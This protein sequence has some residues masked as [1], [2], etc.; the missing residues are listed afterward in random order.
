M[1]SRPSALLAGATCLAWLTLTTGYAGA[2]TPS[3]IDLGGEP[4]PGGVGSTTPDRPTALD[5]GLWADTIGGSAARNTH[6]F[7]YDRRMRD[8]TVHVGVIAAP[9]AD[10]TDSIAV[11]V[12]VLDDDG[13]LKSCESDSDTTGFS[14]PQAVIGAA[15]AVGPSS[16][17]ATDR[18]DCLRAATLQVEVG[19][20]SGSSSTSE[21]PVAIKIVEEAPVEDRASLPEPDEDVSFPVPE[22]GGAREVAGGTSFADAPALDPSADGV[23]VSSTVR[24]GTEQLWRVGVGWGQQLAVRATAPK[25]PSED[26]RYSDPNVRLRLVDPRRAV[27]ADTN[28][29]NDDESS[30]GTYDD[31]KTLDLVAGTRPLRYLD[32][33]ADDLPVVPGDYWVALS[34]APADEDEK[35]LDVP[36]EVTVAVTGETD[37]APGYPGVATSP[38]DGDQVASYSPGKPFLVADGT[39]AAVASGNPVVGDDEGDGWLTGRR[40]AGLGVAAVSVACLAG[41]LVRLRARR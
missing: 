15:V 3:A 2:A 1:R 31:G 35:P 17:E 11:K 5:P 22:P 12:G 16:A 9:G 34:V 27:F 18:P 23:T 29:T 4:V 6:H 14:T 25:R 37:G 20:S 10:T 7:T 40:G 38:D 13:V 39:F 33:F 19:R 28:D 26:G 36:F 24:Q 32:R 21:L 8:S 30:D 41:G